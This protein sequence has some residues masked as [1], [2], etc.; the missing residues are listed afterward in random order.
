MKYKNLDDD[1]NLISLKSRYTLQKINSLME[2]MKDNKD[3]EIDIDALDDPKNIEYKN[4][5]LKKK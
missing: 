4:K 3:E 2:D 1:F 5:I